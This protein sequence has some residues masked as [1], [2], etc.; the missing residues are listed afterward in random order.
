MSHRILPMSAA[1]AVALLLGATIAHADMSKKVIDTFK[2]Q[3]VVT[4]GPVEASGDDKSVID[5]YKKARLKEAKSKMNDEDVPQWAFTYTAFIGKGAG[6]DSLKF[7]FYTDDKE[8]RYA[9]DQRITGI[10]PK[11]PV[12][13]GT[14]EISEDDGLAKGKSY[15][16]KLTGEVKGKETLLAKTTLKME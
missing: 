16:I 7:E 10:D 12:L 11:D 4:D 2:G 15:E 8:H 13:T 5:A 6:V 14:I 3:I 9:A 1:T